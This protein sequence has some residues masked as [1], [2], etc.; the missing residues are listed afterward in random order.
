MVW[1]FGS[2]AM[3]LERKHNIV[4]IDSSSLPVM[5]ENITKDLSTDQFNVYII[6]EAIRTGLMLKKP[7]KTPKFVSPNL[8]HS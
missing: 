7:K 1:S 2:N 4:K 3:E 6:H 8:G 5:P